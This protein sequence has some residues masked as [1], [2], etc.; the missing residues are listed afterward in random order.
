MRYRTGGSANQTVCADFSQQ[1]GRKSAKFETLEFIFNDFGAALKSKK[2]K[3]IYIYICV[4]LWK[5]VPC[6]LTFSM[7]WRLDA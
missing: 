7:N 4:H 5:T 3:A 1:L 6:I 2:L